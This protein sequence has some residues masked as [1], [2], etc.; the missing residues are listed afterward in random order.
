VGGEQVKRHWNL[1]QV[2]DS[3]TNESEPSKKRASIIAIDVKTG[4]STIP[5][6]ESDGDLSFGLMASGI[7][8]A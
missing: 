8:V 4:V 5:R 6:D 3:E 7:A 1:C 2:R